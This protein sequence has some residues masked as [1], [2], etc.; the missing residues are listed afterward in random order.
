MIR[1]PPRS[2]QSRSS[3]ASDVYKRQDLTYNPMTLAE[4]AARAPEFD[5]HAWATA[6][7]TPDGALDQ[8][9]V[10]EPDFAVGFARAWAELPVEQWQAWLRYHLVSARAPYLHLSLIHISEP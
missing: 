5:W 9:V 6:L 4:L 2:T 10:R 1:R 3:A 7:G 8:L